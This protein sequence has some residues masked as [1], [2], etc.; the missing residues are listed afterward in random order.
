MEILIKY[1]SQFALLLGLIGFIL[2]TIFDYKIKNKE[3]RN[4]FFYELKAQKIIELYKSIVEIQMIIDRQSGEEM[5]RK[6]FTKRIQL[7]TF[8]WES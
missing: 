6:M 5:R 8:F 1:W 7:D 3:L 4:K 2:K